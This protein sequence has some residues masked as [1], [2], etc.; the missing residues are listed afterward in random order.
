MVQQQ[1]IWEN[2]LII[3]Q[4]GSGIERNEVLKTQT[5][6]IQLEFDKLLS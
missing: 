4:N 3:V 6:T 1:P 2:P 5:E